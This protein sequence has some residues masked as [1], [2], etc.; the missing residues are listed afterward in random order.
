MPSNLV[1]VIEVIELNDADLRATDSPMAGHNLFQTGNERN[2]QTSA[3]QD[4]RHHHSATP[5]SYPSSLGEKTI[6]N[7]SRGKDKICCKWKF[8]STEMCN[9]ICDDVD[10]RD[11]S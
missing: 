1:L 5:S 2:T 8:S 9:R 11:R 3:W 10:I 7:I 6:A 4:R